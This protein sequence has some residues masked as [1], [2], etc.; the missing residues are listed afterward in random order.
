ML[1]KIET[2][3]CYCGGDNEAVYEF[4]EGTSED[5]ILDYASELSF[6]NANSIGTFEQAEKEGIEADIFCSYEIL[7]ES[8]RAEVMERYGEI[9]L[10]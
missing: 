2:S 1:V 7:D 5:E 3:T 9:L 8:E 4:P 10:P 6:E